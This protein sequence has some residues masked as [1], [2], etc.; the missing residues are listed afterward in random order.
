MKERIMTTIE[1]LRLTVIEELIENKINGTT[2]AHKLHIS[3]RQVKR[4]KKKFM[5][6]GHNS[7][8]HAS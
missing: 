8:I 4:L 5:K 6:N 7:L 1:R 3:I 2:A